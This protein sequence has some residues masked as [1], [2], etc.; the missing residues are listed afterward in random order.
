MLSNIDKNIKHLSTSSKED[1]EEGWSIASVGHGGKKLLLTLEKKLERKNSFN[2][3][4]NQSGDVKETN[5]KNVQKTY[6][7]NERE[8][9]M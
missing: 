2:G 1:Y 5:A 7:V 6:L 3:F 8:V 9:Y 4:N